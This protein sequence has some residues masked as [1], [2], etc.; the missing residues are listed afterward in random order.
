MHAGATRREVLLSG[1]PKVGG[2]VGAHAD[3]AGVFEDFLVGEGLEGGEVEGGEVFE[4]VPRR[5]EE[6]VI[7]GHDGRTIV[8]MRVLCER[9]DVEWTCADVGR[10]EW[11]YI[12]LALLYT[13]IRWRPRRLRSFADRS[14]V[15]TL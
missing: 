3:H 1:N 8:R 13:F 4:F 15:L 14:L 5:V 2:L 11:W 10:R 7:D 12:V 6:E 9:Q